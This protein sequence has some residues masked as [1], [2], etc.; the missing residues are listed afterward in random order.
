MNK[1]FITICLIFISI[2]VLT[3]AVFLG[4]SQKN[5]PLY[6]NEEQISFPAPSL[7]LLNQKSSLALFFSSATPF[8]LAGVFALFIIYYIIKHYKTVK[9]HFFKLLCV[10]LCVLC[11][12]TSVSF[13]V[14][15]ADTTF[16]PVSSS[17]YYGR[18][19]LETM[20]NSG[21]LLYAYDQ[22]A[23]GIENHA[24]EISVR[25]IFHSVNKDEWLVVLYS[26]LY[27]YPQHFWM[28][29]SYRYSY[30]NGSNGEITIVKIL[31]NYVF[32]ASELAPARETFN[33][34]AQEILSKVNPSMGE[35]QL[36]LT[37]HNELC[38]RI[39]YNDSEHAHSAYGGLVTGVAVCEGYGKAYQY[40]LNP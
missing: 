29:S 13:S 32:S 23:E 30:Q 11:I 19:Q 14:S 33:T 22:M 18:K 27:D 26:Y 31:P 20:D 25:N 35:Y 39:T 21:A 7:E 15:L 17:D 2:L 34:K 12:G 8:F 9:K 10:T 1:K 4:I 3:S 40:L 37:I 38:N 24:S 5:Q 16:S 36:A 28:D 6:Y